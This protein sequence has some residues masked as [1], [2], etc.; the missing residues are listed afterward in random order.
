MLKN[1]DFLVRPFLKVPLIRR[2]DPKLLTFLGLLFGIMI[3]F[4]LPLRLPFLALFCLALSGLFDL[5]DGAVARHSN[6]S[7]ELGAVFD[8]TSDRVVEFLIVLGLFLVAP[9]ERGLMSLLMLGSI[10]FCITTFLVVG[11]FSVNTTEKSFYYSPGLIER[12]EAFAFFA[13]MMVFPSVFTLLS[14][15]FTGLVLLT[16]L[17]RIYQFFLNTSMPK[18]RKIKSKK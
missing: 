8:I 9:E 3:P 12:G 4:F 16:G 2:A 15:L 14:S 6:A 5:L 7:S 10:L 13:L 1:K 18:T 17:I 11:I